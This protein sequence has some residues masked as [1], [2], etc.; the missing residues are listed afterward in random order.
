MATGNM[1]RKFGEVF[2]WGSRDMHED[3]QTNRQSSSQY[4]AAL[5]SHTWHQLG[6]HD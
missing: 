3:R 5:L 1:H 4:S 2:Q 6:E